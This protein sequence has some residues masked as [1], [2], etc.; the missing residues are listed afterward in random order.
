[1]TTH[2]KLQ[3][4][5]KIIDDFKHSIDD[6]ANIQVSMLSH[7]IEDCFKGININNYQYLYTGDMFSG[8]MQSRF[9]LKTCDN[10]EPRNVF[11]LQKKLHKEI[12]K[13]D[14]FF[15]DQHTILV[16]LHGMLAYYSS[17]IIDKVIKHD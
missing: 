7:I 12:D 2:K 1:M 14:V 9:Y 16:I 11:W 6:I 17:Y 5:E 10:I 4:L 3:E 8:E 13:I 15:A